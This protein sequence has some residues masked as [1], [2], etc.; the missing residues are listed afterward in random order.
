M[1]GQNEG[2][3]IRPRL[4]FF[5]PIRTVLPPAMISS[6]RSII[7]PLRRGWRRSG[8]LSRRTLLRT[9][10]LPRLILGTA[11]VH[12]SVRLTILI[13]PVVH[14]HIRLAILIRPVVHTHVRL[15]ILIRAIVRAHVRLPILI[16][17]VVR[18]HIRLA[19]LVRPII[20]LA[21]AAIVTRTICRPI[22]VVAILR[23]TIVHPVG[24][25][26]IVIYARVVPAPI[27][28]RR[29]AM[30]RSIEGRNPSLPRL[31]AFP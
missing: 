10:H 9:R 6:R 7:M 26:P 15:P 27:I 19:I 2:G 5:Q 21:S 23:R 18:A 17:P 31:L 14:A 16:R 12:S 22:R 13:R 24:S 20:H 1:R 11:F 29:S 30:R 3:G 8:C 28:D 25:R 4:L